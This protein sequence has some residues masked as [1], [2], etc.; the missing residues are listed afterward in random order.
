MVW[1]GAN[2]VIGSVDTSFHDRGDGVG[3]EGYMEGLGVI[4]DYGVLIRM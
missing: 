3:L 4:S 2:E 1:E